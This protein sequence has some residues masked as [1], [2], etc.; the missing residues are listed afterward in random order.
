MQDNK[1]K[2][3]KTIDKNSKN[4]NTNEDPQSYGNPSSISSKIRRIKS[5]NAYQNSNRSKKDTIGKVK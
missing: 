2:K 3:C 1:N 5:K 4:K